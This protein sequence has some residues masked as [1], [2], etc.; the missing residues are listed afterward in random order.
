MTA[1]QQ[2]LFEPEAPELPSGWR[3][4]ADFI[5]AS[6]EAALLA[7]IAALPLAAARY[8]SFTAKRRVATFGAG[9][10]YDANRTTPADPI[11]TWLEPVRARAARWAG[12]E[13][14]AFAMALVAEYAP[15]TGLGWHRDVPD[16]ELV[17]GLSLGGRARMTMRPWPPH[18]PKKAD[19]RSLEL[20]PRSAYVLEGDARWRWQHA[21][22]PTRELRWSITLR[23]RASGR[24]A[25][26]RARDGR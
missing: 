7:H 4:V 11:P 5:D 22:A 17:F 16:Y 15:G 10:D 2:T 14:T 1:A 12:V 21:I 9:Y 25:A 6:E 19:V 26:R 18:A 3:Y 24:P 8:K 23:T 20:A 13:P